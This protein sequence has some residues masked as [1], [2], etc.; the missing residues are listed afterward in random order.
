MIME[1]DSGSIHSS[2]SSQV[3]SRSSQS[4]RSDWWGRR[5]WIAAAPHLSSPHLFPTRSYSGRTL[6]ARLYQQAT[7]QNSE[8]F[9][10]VA[11]TMCLSHH[12]YLP[13]PSSGKAPQEDYRHYRLRHQRHSGSLPLLWESSWKHRHGHRHRRCS[14]TATHRMWRLSNAPALRKLCPE[15]WIS[16]SFGLSKP[17][18]IRST[19]GKPCR[20]RS[21]PCK[22]GARSCLRLP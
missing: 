9:C 17:R 16:S 11:S 1:G 6:L 21:S 20:P 7:A 8:L 19:R 4:I 5:A 2:L 18:S 22:T 15:P 13:S 14:E 12:C 10:L 3:G